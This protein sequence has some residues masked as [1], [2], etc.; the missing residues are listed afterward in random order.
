[1]PTSLWLCL[2][3]LGFRRIMEQIENGEV[4]NDL[5]VIVMRYA[6]MEQRSPVSNGSLSIKELPQSY[7]N[8]TNYAGDKDLPDYKDAMHFQI[9]LV[10]LSEESKNDYMP[11]LAFNNPMSKHSIKYI[12]YVTGDNVYD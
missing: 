4:D 9:H 8:G 3:D 2:Q 10:Y 12:K 1:M 7:N 6:T 5:F 11:L